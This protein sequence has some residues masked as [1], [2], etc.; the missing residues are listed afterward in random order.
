M[1]IYKKYS[2]VAHGE[3]IRKDLKQILKQVWRKEELKKYQLELNYF[4]CACCALI[5]SDVTGNPNILQYWIYLGSK[6]P[7]DNL[8]CICKV[9]VK[10]WLGLIPLNRDAPGDPGVK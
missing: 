8:G 6:S 3:K 5:G 7:L 10:N 1:I 2:P 4:F 9:A